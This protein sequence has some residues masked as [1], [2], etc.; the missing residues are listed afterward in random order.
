MADK[1]LTVFQF[2]DHEIR[3]KIKD[4]EP[5]F[6]AADVCRVLSLGQVTRAMD[7]LEPDE[8]GLLEITHPQKPEETIEVNA[9]NEPGLFNLILGSRKPEAKLFRRWV[10]HEVL[11]SIR[12]HGMYVKEE[13]LD[14]PDLLLDVVTKLTEERRAHLAEKKARQAAEARALVAETQVQEQAPMVAFAET[15][16]AS[17]DAILVRELAKVIHEKFGV[18]TGEKRLYKTLRSWGMI[19]PNATEPSQRGMDMGLFEVT[20]RTVET[21]FGPHLV[22]TTKVTPRGQVYIVDR[23]MKE[24]DPVG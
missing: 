9:V 12:R 22:R 17:K 2:G 5:W 23:L 20:Q 19:L 21:T 3:V 1:D 8:G 11:P 13:L 10:T 15:C 18:S 6:V 16:L 7:R 24:M 4:G 14:N